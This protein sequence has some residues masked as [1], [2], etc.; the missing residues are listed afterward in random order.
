MLPRV[1]HCAVRAMPESRTLAN[2]NMSSSRSIA[3]ANQ[4]PTTK[5]MSPRVMC[6]SIASTCQRST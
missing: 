2:P 1:R 5:G 4:L 3:V 6:P